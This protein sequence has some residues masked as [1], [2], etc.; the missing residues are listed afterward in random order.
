MVLLDYPESFNIITNYLYTESIILHIDTA[1]FVPDNSKLPLLQ[2]TVR[3]RHYP[4]Y[5]THTRSHTGLLG[6]LAQGNENIDQLLTG[7]MC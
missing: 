6:P 2:Q 7:K 3:T 4:L 5:I 1:E